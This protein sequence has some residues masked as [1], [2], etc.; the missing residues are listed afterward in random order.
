MAL[1]LSPEG[2]ARRSARRPWIT[3]GVWVITLVVG[4]VLVGSLL[5]D[6]LTTEFVFTNTPESQRGVDLIEELRGPFSTNEVIIVQS[7]SLTVD[8]PAFEAFATELHGNVAAL[9][10]EVIKGGTFINYFQTRA[11]FLVSQDRRTTIMPFEM[12]GDF[13]DASDNIEDVVDV[14][15]ESRTPEGFNV[16]MAGQATVGLDFRKISEEDLLTGEAFGVPIA[17]VILVLVFGALVAALVPLVLAALSIVVALAAAAIVGQAFEL[18]FFVTNIITMIGLAVGIDYSLFVVARYREERLRGLE[19]REAIA[20]AGSTATRAVVFS[21]MTVML[22]LIGMLIIPFNVFISL[23]IGAIFVVIASVLASLT[24]L[25]AI[26]SVL[27][28][29]VFKLSLPIVGRSQANVDPDATGGIWDQIS[30]AVMRQPLVS[31]VL[32]GGVLI[33]ATVPAFDMNIGFAG[34][35]TMPDEVRSKEGFLVLDKEFSAGQV[36]PAEIVIEGDINS[37]PVLIAV[38]RLRAE[39]ANDDSFAVPRELEVS[40]AGDVAAPPSP[41]LEIQPVKKPRTL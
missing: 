35:S 3:I 40:D 32:A 21:G 4:L 36:T 15:E 26:L 12:A 28:D 33:A 29:R 34:V 13:D 7:E 17:L 16:L 6:G 30:R 2:F 5:G 27:G 9:G 18:S 1:N 39:L 41:S 19:N 22:A 23:G 38:D 25:P 31:L 14:V 37:G 20:R 24:L 8:D 10:P 11:P